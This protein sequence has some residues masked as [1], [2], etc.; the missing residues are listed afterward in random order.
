MEGSVVSGVRH[1]LNLKKTEQRLQC[2]LRDFSFAP[3]VEIIQPIREL[4]RTR[5]QCGA[6]CMCS[7]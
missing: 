5:A 3:V 7:I 4:V 6:R 1:Y 2:L